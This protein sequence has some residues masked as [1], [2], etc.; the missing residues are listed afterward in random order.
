MPD[1]V[2][3]ARL[4]QIAVKLR[5]ATRG[6]FRPFGTEF[7]DFGR[8]RRLSERQVA[9]FEQRNAAK[10]PPEYRSFITGVASGGAGPGYG[11]YSLAESVTK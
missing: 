11:L 2:V 10:L 3:D 7:H 1:A 5:T 8:G 9:A 4:E 6:K